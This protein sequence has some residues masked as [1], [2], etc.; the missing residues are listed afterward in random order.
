M[1]FRP[2]PFVL[3][4]VQVFLALSLS[5][6]ASAA[7]LQGIY[8]LV[9][10]RV[11]KHA[12]AFSFS[13]VDGESDAFKITDAQCGIHVQCTTV[14]ACARGLYT[15]LTEYGG[16]DIWWTGSRLDW[17]PETLPK[18]CGFDIH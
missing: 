7:D 1:L 4:T 17:V 14:S 2:G 13:L 15:Y 3:L 8:A 6:A 10:R 9:K 12:D 16:V 18:H 5:A 11:P